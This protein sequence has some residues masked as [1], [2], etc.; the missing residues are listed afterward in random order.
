MTFDTYKRACE[1]MEH[2]ARLTNARDTIK[3][4]TPNGNMKIGDSYISVPLT[5]IA[6]TS[7]LDMVKTMLLTHMETK[8]AAVDA[9]FQALG[10]GTYESN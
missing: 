3:R 9:E 7:M 6:D 8:L 10:G 2:R 5:G 4:I 1:L